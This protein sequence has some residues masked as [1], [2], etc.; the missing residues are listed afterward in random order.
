[1]L[2]HP[3]N[4]HLPP[5]YN[6]SVRF[7]RGG[8]S[9]SSSSLLSTSSLAS[10]PTTAENCSTALSTFIVKNPRNLLFITY[11]SCTAPKIRQKITHR[12]PIPPGPTTTSPSPPLQRLVGNFRNNRQINASNQ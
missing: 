10:S 2:Q 8:S 1:M 9:S 12:P 7:S 3:D 6:M 4:C 11:L 5:Q